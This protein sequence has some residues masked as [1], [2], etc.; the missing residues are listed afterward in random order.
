MTSTFPDILRRNFVAVATADYDAGAFPPLPGVGA[1]VAALRDW[2][3]DSGLGARR[4]G[5][6]H[7]ELAEGP[8]RRQVEAALRDTEEVWNDADAVVVFI[9]GHGLSVHGKHWIVLRNTDTGKLHRTA[10]STADL[11]GWLTETQAGHLLVI[12]DLCH[13][14]AAAADTVRLPDF[15]PSWLVLASVT[16]GQTAAP[17]ALTA[18]VTGF[19]AELATPAGQKY[20]HGEYLLVGDFLDAIQRGLGERQRL[21]MLHSGLPTTGP[22]PCLPNPR[23]RPEPDLVERPRQDLAIRREDL[24]AHWAP[25]ARGSDTG[26]L[27]TGRATLMGHLVEQLS[28]TPPRPIVVTGRA[29]SGKSAVL[30]RLVTLSDATFRAQH[31]ELVDTIPAKLLPAE[32]SIDVAVLATGKLPH[33]L[34]GQILE[35]LDVPLT[36]AAVPT[37]ADLQQAWTGWLNSHARVVTA[38]I[39]AVDEAKN[40]P[41]LLDEVLTTL[42]PPGGGRVR[43]IV[44]VRSPGGPDD[45][46]TTTSGLPVAGLALADQFVT[47]LHAER[48]PVDDD[49]WW[50]DGDLAD[51]AFELL[52]VTV[53][54]PYQPD[55][56]HAN[57]RA[58][59]GEIAGRARR[60]FLVTQLAATNLARGAHRIDRTDPAWL[61]TLDDGVLGVFRADLHAVFPNRDKRERAIHLLRAVA[62][63]Y[64]RG[65]PWSQI[66]PLVANAVADRPGTYGDND[67]VEL[68]AS[69]I[70]GYLVTD[71]EDGVTVYRLFHDALR[72]TLRERSSDL[73]D[74]DTP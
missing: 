58:V 10:L 63:A 12:L 51:Y 31:R 2:L 1:E 16:H 49:P 36:A 73:L 46:T 42:A 26:W 38:V 15:P 30:G 21:A 59:A 7:P 17:G 18:A 24:D 27:F 52:T 70:G 40:P 64:G 32:G 66:W 37:L 9:T 67:I 23:H 29:G 5:M 35:A 69:R 33:E 72:S 74:P 39:D 28:T 55:T 44:G 65:L 13:A 25:K 54:S 47:R 6:P 8:T 4:F 19:L 61:R 45:T 60:S 71:H 43:L 50:N 41:Q 68:L 11:V 22:S 53:N 56:H 57:A 62:F 48:I 14:G 34:L 20:N 3:C